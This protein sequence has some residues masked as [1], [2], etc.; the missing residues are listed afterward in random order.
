[1]YEK[2]WV[3]WCGG[4]MIIWGPG[5]V[6]LPALP[7]PILGFHPQF[8]KMAAATP[9]IVSTFQAVRR[10]EEGKAKGSF[11]CHLFSLSKNLP[12]SPSL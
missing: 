5:Y 3:G 7:F 12:S 9:A 10:K 6:S 11:S 2:S 4:F 1:M 8:F